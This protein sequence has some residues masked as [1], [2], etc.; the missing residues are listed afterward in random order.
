MDTPPRVPYGFSTRVGDTD[1]PRHMSDTPAGMSEY[2]LINFGT[3][4]NMD[5]TGTHHVLQRTRHGHGGATFVIFQKNF[6]GNC[7][8]LKTWRGQNEKKFIYTHSVEQ[9]FGP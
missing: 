6:S 5:T 4:H 2:F 8:I 3:R 9:N 7:V 1:T